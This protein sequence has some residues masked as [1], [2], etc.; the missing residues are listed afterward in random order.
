MNEPL[1]LFD[2][3]TAGYGA[4][5]VVHDVDLHVEAGEVVG[6][7]G[8]N[9][10]GKTTLVRV[11]SRAL[12]P[13][14]GRVLVDGRDPFSMQARRAARLVAVVPQDVLPVFSFTAL[15]VVLMG[16]SPYRSG[17]RLGSPEDWS[18][19]W[20]AMEAAGVRH[21]ADR[22]M[23]TLSG[24]ERR[25]V[26]LAQALAQDAPVLL[27]DEA[28]THLDLLHVT[29]LVSVVRRLAAGGRAVLAIYHDLNLAA[30]SCDR[31]YAMSGGRVVAEGTPEQ[32]V[33]S[34]LL[35]RVYEVRIP[36]FEN[37]VSGRPMV[38][39]AVA[40]PAG[41]ARASSE[42]LRRSVLQHRP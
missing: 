1:L 5:P 34:E 32:V 9:G 18:C 19:V 16:R 38:A 42:P 41:A 25:R 30:A 3:V 7:I 36:V 24:G 26:V 15:E 8:P 13:V 28:T 17:W 6:L 20:P 10:S 14:A 2:G 12:R 29:E 39:P 23:E 31:L 40:S 4:E 37:P 35:Q 33:T 21:L 27:L 22:P 11:A